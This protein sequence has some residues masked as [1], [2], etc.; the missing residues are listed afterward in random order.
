MALAHL[1]Y[2]G[3]HG[4][5]H[6]FRV[7]L[8]SNAYFAWAVGGD[9]ITANGV[10]MLNRRTAESG[11]LGP[12]S[13]PERR[14]AVLDIPMGV[15][16]RE[17][18]SVQILSFRT[19]RLEG[20]AASDILDV[21]TLRLRSAQPALRLPPRARAMQAPGEV[22]TAMFLESI[23]G[24]VSGLLPALAQLAPVVLPMISNL[25]GG[26]RSG[27]GATGG[28]AQ[29]AAAPAQGAASADTQRLIAQLVQQVAQLLGPNGHGAAPPAAAARQVTAHALGYSEAKAIPAALLAALPAL[30]PLLQQVLTPQTIQSVLQ[31]AD[32]NRLL[33]T[34]T[35]GLTQL[36]QVGLQANQQQLDHLRALNP[37]LGDETAIRLL[38]S[39][40]VAMSSLRQRR[41]FRRTDRVQL[42]LPDVALVSVGGRPEVLFA[43]EREWRFPVEVATA[44][45]IK[46]AE[47]HVALQRSDTMEVVHE[48]TYE[49]AATAGGRLEV[50]AAVPAHVVASLTPGDDHLVTLTLTWPT[51]KGR[52]GAT[53][54]Q[55]VEAAGA[56]TF[57]SVTGEGEVVALNDVVAHRAWWHKVWGI[58]LDDAVR[59]ADVTVA[60]SYRLV[61]DGSEVTRRES[62]VDAAVPE[63]RREMEGTVTSGLDCGLVALNQLLHTLTGSSLGPDELTALRSPALARHLS[64]QAK[65][66]ITLH[67]GR[68]DELAI[69]VWPEVKLH[70]LV[71]HRPGEIAPTGQIRS[72]SEAEVRFPFPALAHVVGAAT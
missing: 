23:A 52:L 50:V 33:S 68:G 34:I 54:T 61:A 19:E 48:Q 7:D 5:A 51:G 60:Y 15:F 24:V 25:L 67:G 58:T 20:P 41:P 29:P 72:L 32:P 28:A 69:W 2:E 6:R 3:A 37:G 27:G 30:M 1:R 13:P 4:D 12:L 35:N 70:R 55:L 16:D 64:G 21:G 42:K 11:L 57:G 43:P 45:P 62:T 17:S 40:S 39:A 65:G 53:V 46:K 56:V 8:G 38:E 26:G 9:P 22:S 18:S 71:L 36:A 10:T 31:T 44:H 63:G 47:L 14:N 49:V 66:R 59:R